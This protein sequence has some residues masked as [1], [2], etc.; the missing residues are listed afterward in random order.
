[1]FRCVDFAQ[2]A[3]SVQKF[4]FDFLAVIGAF[5]SDDLLPDTSK[6]QCLF[7]RGLSI[8][9]FEEFQSMPASS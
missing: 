2:L 4:S 3:Y 8:D 6:G 5:K 9:Y 7:T 1:M